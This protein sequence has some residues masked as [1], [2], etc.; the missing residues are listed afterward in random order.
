[1]LEARHGAYP[2]ETDHDRA[3]AITPGADLGKTRPAVADRTRRA[4]VDGDR[5]S[6]PDRTACHHRARPG[7]FGAEDHRIRASRLSNA[8]FL[9]PLWGPLGDH[10]LYKRS[11]NPQAATPSCP[12]A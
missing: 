7:R 4:G 1:M 11:S 8:R 6:E 10:T 3:G 12:A 5:T 9:V 2:R